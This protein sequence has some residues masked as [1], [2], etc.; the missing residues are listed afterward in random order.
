MI[1]KGIL[2]INELNSKFYS[3][4]SESFDRSREFYWEGFNDTLEYIKDNSKILDLG[5]G[6][7]RFYK[8]LEEKG[9]NID[10]LGIDNNPKFIE[11]NQEKYPF[12]KFA[13]IDAITEIDQIKEKY[14]LAVVYGVTHHIPS[15]EYRKSWFNQLSKLIQKNGYLIIS[16]WNFDESKE[17]QKFQTEFYQKEEGDYFLGWKKDFSEHRFCHKFSVEEIIEI[18]NNFKE[19]SIVKDFNKEDNRYL[20]FQKTN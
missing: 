5:C 18:K 16:F 10:Y 11:K 19:F 9:L 7:A 1:K 20:I 12:A 13:N 14:N 8:F 4:H 6:N 2:E 17:D 15:K 3:F